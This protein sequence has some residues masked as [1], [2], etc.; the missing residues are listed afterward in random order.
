MGSEHCLSLESETEVDKRLVPGFSANIS[1]I[2]INTWV[3]WV[4]V[5]VSKGIENQTYFLGTLSNAAFKSFSVVLIER[6]IFL[7]VTNTEQH[8]SKE[9]PENEDQ[10][11]VQYS[12]YNVFQFLH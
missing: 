6:I 2:L 3:I 8:S 1:S 12:Y 4:Y 7:I 10:P 5:N 11:C 9:G